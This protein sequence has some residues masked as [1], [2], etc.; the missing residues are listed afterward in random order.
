MGFG[1]LTVGYYLTY[2]LGM[3]W[4][5]EIW[6]ILM[7]VLG[8][9]VVALALLRLS[10]YEESF[11]WALVLDA[12]MLLPAAYRLLSWLSDSLLWDLAFLNGTADEI[13]RYL[14]LAIFLGFGAAL[15]AAVRAIAADVGD[16]RIVA[17]A[18]R[19]LIFLG[20]YAVS[21]ILTLLPFD[22]AGLFGLGAMLVQLVYHVFVGIMLVSCYMRICDEGDK[23]MPLK[24]SRFAWVNRI[25]EER[26]LREQRAAD[27]VTEY[28]EARL[29]RQR[30]KREQLLRE[31]EEKKRRGRRK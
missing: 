12:L 6:G 26:A 14:E 11:R 23:E 2:L 19:N 17:A 4:K 16:T 27:S 8:C 30:E 25:R 28:A 1:I 18:V 29:R 24:R 5:D 31:E 13:A 9:V 3:I 21:L 10:E 7:I 15:L 20:I 22:F